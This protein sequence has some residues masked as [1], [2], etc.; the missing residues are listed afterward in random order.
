M[1][2][3]KKGCNEDGTPKNRLVI[4]FKKFNNNTIPDRNPMPDP[5]VILPNLGEHDSFQKLI[6]NLDSIKF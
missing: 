4:D 6:W 2:N 3:W 1:G 5:S